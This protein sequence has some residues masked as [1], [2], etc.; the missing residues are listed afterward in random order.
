MIKSRLLINYHLLY[1]I[2]NYFYINIFIVG[3]NLTNLF[4]LI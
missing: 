3:I 2:L 1:Q 4:M